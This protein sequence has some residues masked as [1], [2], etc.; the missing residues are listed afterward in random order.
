MMLSIPAAESP[1]L[2]DHT[3]TF[4]SAHTTANQVTPV[5]VM[6]AK[7]DVLHPSVL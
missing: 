4:I 5:L 1:E 7:R 3:I 6:Y 2:V